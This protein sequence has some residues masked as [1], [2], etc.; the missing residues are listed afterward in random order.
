MKYNLK[1]GKNLLEFNLVDENGSFNIENNEK[2]YNA[3]LVKID[4]NLYS[5]TTVRATGRI[6]DGT[7]QGFNGSFWHTVAQSNNGLYIYFTTG[8]IA[9]GTIAIYKVLPWAQKKNFQ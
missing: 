8:N 4:S 5:M 9:S 2:N 7:N 3:E 1:I 6:D